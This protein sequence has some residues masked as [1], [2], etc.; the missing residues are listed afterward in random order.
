V[1]G[2]WDRFESLSMLLTGSVIM[3]F[4]RTRLTR[5]EQ[6]DFAVTAE[7]LRTLGVA[8]D[9]PEEWRRQA[10][11]VDVSIS[12]A[13][14]IY[15]LGR[16]KI[17]YALH[18][19]L[20]STSP[21]LVL[22]Q[23]DIAPPWDSGVLCELDDDYRF[24]RGLEFDAKLVLNS[25]FERGLRFRY[26]GDWVEGWLLGTGL[27]A[28]PAEYGNGFSAPIELL[29]F[30][31][32]EAPPFRTDVSMLVLRS[33]KF[34]QGRAEQRRSSIF[35]EREA[36]ATANTELEEVAGLQDHSED[37]VDR[38]RGLKANANLATQRN[39]NGMSGC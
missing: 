28:V 16:G 20:V 17:V 6:L 36:V 8:I 31:P 26:R 27:N 18:V 4:H 22:S 3:P 9:I 29:L 34:G 24:A 23:F 19:R 30:G 32:A 38:A 13:S 10:R 11:F 5:S 12:P 7:E 2:G 14:T 37:G 35:G 21:N 25:R 15:E 33:A 1:Q 39:E